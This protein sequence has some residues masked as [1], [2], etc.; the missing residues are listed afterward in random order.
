MNGWLIA[1]ALA[2]ALDAGSTCAALARPGLVEGNPLLPHT[3]PAIAAVKAGTVAGY[4]IAARPLFR[5]H[6]RAARW[7]SVVVVA[8]PVA[9]TVHNLGTMRR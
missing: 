7:L 8:V 3:C 5:T 9:A 2:H 6:P 4:A 1:V